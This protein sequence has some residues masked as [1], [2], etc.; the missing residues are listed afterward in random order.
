M[1]RT[2][3]KRVITMRAIIKR[4]KKRQFEMAKTYNGRHSLLITYLS[5]SLSAYY[6][7]KVK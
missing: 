4:A 7:N 3:I 5:T 2:I 1:N 6:L